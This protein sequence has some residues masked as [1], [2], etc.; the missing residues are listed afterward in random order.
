MSHGFNRQPDY[1]W[2][3]FWVGIGI[4]LIALLGVL[5]IIVAAIW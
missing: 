3:Q 2:A 1:E 4:M 5:G